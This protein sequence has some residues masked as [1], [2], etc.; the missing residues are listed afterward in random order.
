MAAAELDA[1]DLATGGVGAWAR[2]VV[3]FGKEVWRVTYRANWRHINVLDALLRLNLRV[4]P[5]SRRSRS[6]SR[7]VLEAGRGRAVCAFTRN[8]ATSAMRLGLSSRRRPRAAV[9]VE[10]RT[11]RT[12]R[13]VAIK[14]GS[15][16]AFFRHGAV[17]AWRQGRRAARVDVEV[18]GQDGRTSQSLFA[19]RLGAAAARLLSVPRLHLPVGASSDHRPGLGTGAVF[20][21]VRLPRFYILCSATYTHVFI[22]QWPLGAQY[23]RCAASSAG[24]APAPS[25]CNRGRPAPHPH[26]H[27]PTRPSTAASRRSQPKTALQHGQHPLPSAIS[28]TRHRFHHKPRQRATSSIAWS[29]TSPVCYPVYP[30]SWPPVAST[31]TV[32]SSA[33]PKSMISRA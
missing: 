31:L 32:W 30:V 11:C 24:N 16:T 23:C 9:S 2:L 22:P 3:G 20:D 18:K 5:R 10:A 6:R 29:R 7:L 33:T 12:L 13:L 19:C 17:G 4:D 25:A 28:S 27:S 26:R 15:R 21:F 1:G 14:A 8:R